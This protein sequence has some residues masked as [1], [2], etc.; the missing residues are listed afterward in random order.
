MHSTRALLDFLNQ[1]SPFELQEAWDNSGLILGDLKSNFQ[2]IYLSLE[3]TQ[4]VLESAKKDSVLI[5]H[6][7]L[8]FSP[9][10]VLNFAQY[11]AKLLQIAIKKNI[12]LIAM[13]TNFDKT[14][15]G[16]Y[17]TSTI[18]GIKNYSQQGFAILFCWEDS[19]ESLCDFIK[20]KF[21]LNTLKIT[22]SHT[23]TPQRVALITGSG[24]SFIRNI[25]EIDCLITGDIK[26][27]DAMEA[28]ALNINLIDCGH[29]ELECYF[30]KI[31]APILTNAGYKVIIS[32]SQNPFSFV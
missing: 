26:Y 7:P 15:F 25:P 16:S 1:T 24:A 4:E 5:T 27:H 29:Y 17:I 28:F 10:K 31:L 20:E 30:G 19:F 22:K 2:H 8:I 11:P 13:H 14:H 6:H 12:Q 9:L 23:K 18:L 32:E 21:H 3:V